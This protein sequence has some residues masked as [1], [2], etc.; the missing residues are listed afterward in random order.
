[1]LA[2]RAPWDVHGA[3]RAPHLEFRP[4]AV[5][6]SIEWVLDP[7]VGE[8]PGR[9]LDAVPEVEALHQKLELR[10]ASNG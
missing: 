3:N 9:L 7:R 2:V 1:M 8:I 6:G 10:G 4:E 5:N